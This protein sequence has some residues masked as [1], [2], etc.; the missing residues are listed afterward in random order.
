MAAVSAAVEPAFE[1]TVKPTHIATF[2]RA[3]D[4]AECAAVGATDIAAIVAAIAPTIA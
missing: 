2:R 1:A 4:T 3:V